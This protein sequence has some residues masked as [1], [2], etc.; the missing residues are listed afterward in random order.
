LARHAPV[1]ELVRVV[2]AG[3]VAGSLL[4]V[5]SGVA[6]PQQLVT[7]F[8]EARVIAVIEDEPAWT[9]RLSALE[10]GRVRLIGAAAVSA[11]AVTSGRPD[12][13]VYAQPVTESGRI[14]L[15]PFLHEQSISVTA[16]R[17]GTPDHLI[18][19]ALPAQD[20]RTSDS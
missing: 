6:L 11:Y 19:A 3:V 5:S 4:T 1:T 14:E 2:A 10:A 12:L 16:H 20:G 18:D 7:A 17:L 13:A 8:G 15:L 9:A